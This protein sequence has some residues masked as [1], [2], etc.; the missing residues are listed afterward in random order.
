MSVG[1]YFA[2]QLRQPSGFF[3]RYVM[4]HLL[5]RINVSMNSLAFE[6]L[7]LDSRDQV[8]EV[9][10]GGGDLIARMSSVVSQGRITGV[11]YSQNAVDACSKRFAKFIKAGI[12]DL[13]CADVESLPFKPDTFT[14]ACTVHTLYFWPVPLAALRQFHRVL[15]EDGSLAVC[16]TPRTIMENLGNVIHHGFTLYEPEEVTALLKESGFRDVQIVFGKNRMGE[17]AAVVGKK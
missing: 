1:K 5:N 8:L 9:G 12:I 7:R 2:A 17:C 3:G 15:K 14:K 6:A 16:F 10:F 11:D 4:V 13:H